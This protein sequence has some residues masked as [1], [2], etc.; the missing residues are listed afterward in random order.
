[1]ATIN[2]SNFESIGP[3]VDETGATQ[4]SQTRPIG[5]GATA[6]GQDEAG[7]LA[8]NSTYLWTDNMRQQGGLQTWGDTTSAGAPFHVTSVASGDPREDVADWIFYLGGNRGPV[9][10]LVDHVEAD[11]LITVYDSGGTPITS[12]SASV[13]ATRTLSSISLDLSSVG[14]DCRAVVSTRRSSTNDGS[15]YGVTVLEDASDTS[16][17]GSPEFLALDD[18]AVGGDEPFDAFILHR[19]IDQL[20]AAWQDRVQRLSSFYPAQGRPIMAS[21]QTTGY[22]LGVSRILPGEKTY[23]CDL[24]AIVRDAGVN[25]GLALYPLQGR[26]TLSMREP[27]TAIAITTA[28]TEALTDVD[29]EPYQGRIVAWILLVKSDDSA[30]TSIMSQTTDITVGRYRLDNV[31]SLT[32]T[33]GKRWKLEILDPASGS[34]YSADPLPEP[35][36]VAWYDSGDSAAYVWPGYAEGEFTGSWRFGNYQIRNTVI[37]QLELL[38]W[39]IYCTDTV[40][41]QDLKDLARPGLPPAADVVKRIYARQ[42]DQYL[43]RT[44]T[45]CHRASYDP[46]DQDASGN[47]NNL[48]GSLVDYDDALYHDVACTLI[49]GYDA[50]LDQDGSTTHPRTTTTVAL[51]V[52]AMGWSRESDLG[53]TFRAQLK[54]FSAGSWSASTFTNDVIGN[55]AIPVLQSVRLNNAVL[56]NTADANLLAA[57]DGIGSYQ[58]MKGAIDPAELVPAG[59]DETRVRDALT[60][61]VFDIED[62]QAAAAQRSLQLLLKGYAAN[63]AGQDLTQMSIWTLACGVWTSEYMG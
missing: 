51:L 33:S 15:I 2:P 30:T 36:T 28:S 17:F 7:A 43:R 38:S 41:R 62:D 25:V 31:G 34:R 4:M 9:T 6:D 20:E 63:T 5:G 26:R 19:I 8:G 45:H 47:L 59:N 58:F 18:A 53:L 29:V 1:M 13:G 40:D 16:D 11:T 10:F 44:R 32:W 21:H 35:R 52:M 61:L 14:R 22:V 60:L 37:G 57:N 55:T 48:W 46:D 24:R 49:R 23:A 54:T 42:R 3:L 50:T 39:R 12:G 27:D 56:R